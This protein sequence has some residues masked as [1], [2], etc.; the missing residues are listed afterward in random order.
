MA[1][2]G[3]MDA[4]VFLGGYEYT[5][6][7]NSLSTDYGVEVLDETVFG[8]TT[9]TNIAGLR[10]FAFTMS[11]YRDD[12]GSTPFGDAGG[13]AYSRIGAAREVFSFAPVG[14]SDGQRSFT[15]RGVNGT[16]TPL[17]GTVGD[18]LP[19]ELSGNAAH[20]ELIR[21]VVEGVGTKTSTANSTGTNL[22]A[23]SAAQSLYAG[24]HV[25]AYSGS[26]P[27]LDVK[28]QSDDNSGFSSATDRITFTQNTG[29]IQA[30]WGSVNGAVTDTYWRTV[31]TI[32]GTGPSFTLYVTLGIGSLAIS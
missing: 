27:T 17:S 1:I 24:L 23:L 20:S 11:G 31:M 16:Y 19:F 26:S 25:T 21:G 28:V 13:T 15:I 22:G 18:L 32:G 12:G 30:Q 2:Q 8:D 4:R 9:R 14:T 29:S 7:S 10:T 5:S 3:L 6:F